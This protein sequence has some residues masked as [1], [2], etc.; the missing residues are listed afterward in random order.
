MGSM[1]V[2]VLATGK[3]IFRSTCGTLY[4]LTSIPEMRNY[5]ARPPVTSKRTWTT[6]TI[7]ML[8]RSTLLDPRHTKII[9]TLNISDFTKSLKGESQTKTAFVTVFGINQDTAY[10]GGTNQSWFRAT[11]V[12]CAMESLSSSSCCSATTGGRMMRFAVMQRPTE[13]DY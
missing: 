9:L 4:L 11:T 12:D 10:T 7:Q 2:M 3:E 13:Q 5:T 6:L 8:L 1:E